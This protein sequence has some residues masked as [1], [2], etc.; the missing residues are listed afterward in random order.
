MST[1]T[2]PDRSIC[3]INKFRE[4]GLRITKQRCLIAEHLFSGGHRHVDAA[5][6]YSELLANDKHLS[7]AT[8]YNALRDFEQHNLIRRV[9]VSADKVWYDTDIGDHRHFY[10]PAENRIMDCP[11]QKLPLTKFADPPKGYK[12]TSIDIVVHLAPE[13]QC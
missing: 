8:I 2:I 3:L 11:D 9:A 5:M 10:V 1:I 7:L 4:A 6:L 12:V 13:D